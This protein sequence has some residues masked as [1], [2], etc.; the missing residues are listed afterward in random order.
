MLRRV[1]GLLLVLA[2]G[3]CQYIGVKSTQVSAIKNVFFPAEIDLQTAQWTVGFGGYRAGLTPVTIDSGAAVVGG[4]AF[5]NTTDVIR[6]DGW[7]ISKVVGLDS[8]TPAWEIQ[9]SEGARRFTV[10]GYV[11]ESHQCEPWVKRD[12]DSGLRY[13]QQCYAEQGYI[14]G[15]VN[16]IMVDNLGQVT[17]IK[18][19]V[20]S[21]LKLMHL[22]LVK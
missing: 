5:V 9:E 16:S 8:F 15:Y 2:L 11:V 21:T 14:K 1:C 17:D 20:D 22:R 12:A 4:T 18:Q 6:F 13:E 3:G 10:N 19:V 7:M